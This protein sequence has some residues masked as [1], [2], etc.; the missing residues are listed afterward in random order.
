MDQGTAPEE[1]INTYTYD[2]FGKMVSFTD[3]KNNTTFFTYDSHHLNLTSI[4]NALNYTITASYDFNTGLLDSMTDAK[5]NTTSFQYDILGRVLKKI[6]PDLTEL[7]AVYDDQNNSVTI[8]DELDQKTM[9]FYDGLGRLIQIEKY[10]SPSEKITQTY[11]YNYLNKIETQT[12]PKGFIYSNEYD[13]KGRLIKTADSS[14][15]QLRWR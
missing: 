5:G 10:L 11:S 6:H 2:D 13:S 7:E 3:T 8:Y 1:Y 12:D 9:N 4:T 15:I 14:P